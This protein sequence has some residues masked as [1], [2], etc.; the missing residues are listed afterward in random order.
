MAV[1]SGTAGSFSWTIVK[2]LLDVGYLA[3]T[4]GHRCFF[5][6]ETPHSIVIISNCYK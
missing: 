1:I 6:E 4:L 5:L 2:M 3:V